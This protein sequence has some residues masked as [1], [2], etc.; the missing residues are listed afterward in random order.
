MTTIVW[1]RSPIAGQAR[2][3]VDVVNGAT[4]AAV[5]PA[6]W[7]DQF[8]VR[9]VQVIGHAASTRANIRRWT[10]TEPHLQQSRLTHHYLAAHLGGP[11]RVTRRG[12]GSKIIKDVPARSLTLVPAGSTYEWVTEGPTDF[13]HVYIQPERLA[14]TIGEVFD[15]DP[16]SFTL[17]SKLA[18]DDPLLTALVTTML[19]EAGCSDRGKTLYLEAIYE[20]LIAR[21]VHRHG[22]LGAVQAHKPYALTPTRMRAVR[23][24]IEARLADAIALDD[25]ARIAG[26]SRFHFSRAFQKGQGISPF[27]YLTQQRLSEAKRRLRETDEPLSQIASACGLGTGAQFAT[28]FRRHV[29]M[30]PSHYRAER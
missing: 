11:K 16:G 15:R 30:A 29:G 3:G 9:P 21:V 13:A 18:F 4:N 5:D 28:T 22:N 25:L 10:G 7:N 23:E 2:G 20:T 12:D 24:F 19:S 27:A 26:L 14:K 17:E 6:Q 1:H 8:N